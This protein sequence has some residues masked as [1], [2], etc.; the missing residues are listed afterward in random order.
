M[1]V[2]NKGRVQFLD[3]IR[4]FDYEGQGK[5]NYGYENNALAGIQ[6]RSPLSDAFFNGKN[7]HAIQ[8]GII[9][10]VKKQSGG[11]YNIGYQSQNEL[12]IIMR[13]TYLQNAMNRT[14]DIPGQVATLNKMVI[15]YSVRKIIPAIELYLYYMNDASKNPVPLTQPQNVSMT[16]TRSQEFKRFF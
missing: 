2:Q 5:V 7:I 4:Q 9:E 12:M 14:T 10:G 16:G 6:E 3:S 13:S 8:L 15:D 1:N 11:K